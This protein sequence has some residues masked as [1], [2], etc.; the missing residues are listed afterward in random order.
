[1]VILIGDHGRCMPRGKQFLYDGGLHIPLIIRWPGHIEPGTVCEDL[2]NTLDICKTIVDVAGVTPPQPLHGINLFD[3]E[4]R[5][6]EYIFAARDK[7]D[8]THDAMR[9]VRSRDF[10][11]ILNLMPERPY[12]QFNDYKERQ[13]PSLAVLHLMNLQG[14]L[15][16]V[17]AA[18]MA[19]T[20]PVEEL[21]DLRDDPWE[22]NNLAN[23]PG[24]AEVK[25]EL[26]AE[27]EEWRKMVRDEGVT[28]EFRAGGW[29]SAYPT[30][31]EEQWEAIV[32]AWKPWVF[33]APD[34]KAV[35]PGEFIRESA[36][37][38]RRK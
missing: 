25:K 26:R 23:T 35:H 38:G 21:Y 10:K 8:D 14:R 29:P 22:T 16:S 33:R 12:C 5:E 1:M 9:A 13:Y 37:G 30:K 32:E 19:P 28:P 7:M 2:V 31:S 6:R 24:M 27:L 11:Y 20:K 34:E 17:Q 3:P 36:L 4:I 15:N 18:F